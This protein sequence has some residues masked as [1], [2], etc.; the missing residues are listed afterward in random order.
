MF[1]AYTEEISVNCYVE[2]NNYKYHTFIRNTN[3]IHFI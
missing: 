2:K 3:K 1:S